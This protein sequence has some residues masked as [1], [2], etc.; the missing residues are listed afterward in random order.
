MGERQFP[1]P[2]TGRGSLQLGR[3]VGRLVNYSLR[4]LSR[5]RDPALLCC[6]QKNILQPTCL[7]ENVLCQ[8]HGGQTMVVWG[9]PRAKTQKSRLDQINSNGR[10]VEQNSR[11]R[12][13]LVFCTKVGE[14]R[15]EKTPTKEGQSVSQFSVPLSSVAPYLSPEK[16]W[17]PRSVWTFRS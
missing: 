8:L 15:V 12:S 13:E 4:S 1:P 16:N 6:L 9:D 10:M 7:F 2:S 3:Q 11:G 5:A 14:G 17:R